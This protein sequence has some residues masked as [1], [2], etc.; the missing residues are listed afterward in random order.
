MTEEEAKRII[1]AISAERFQ[2]FLDACDH[3]LV[4]ALRLYYWDGEAS[5][6]FLG[7]LRDF[8]VAMRNSFHAKLAGRYGQADW[9]DSPRVRLTSKG[10]RQVNSAK[11]SLETEFGPGFTA[12]DMV[13]RFTLGFWVG[14]TGRGQNYEMQFWIPALRH[15]FRGY[16]GERGALQL[17][18]DAVRRLRNRVGHHER[19]FHLRLE[20]D[21]ERL[22]RL[23]EY[24]A[25][26]KAALH[27]KFSQIPVVLARRPLVL[28]GAEPVRL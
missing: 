14:L 24:V 10:I 19:I 12:G 18:L 23:M 4:V 3:D 11:R 8:E 7:A 9:W 26:E 2:P 20:E 22:L 17:E 27:R 1:D 15:A 6:A 21:Y 28:S 13:A 25:P 16:L 5:R